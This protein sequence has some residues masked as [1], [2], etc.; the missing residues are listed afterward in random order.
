MTRS[1]RYTWETISSYLMT[2]LITVLFSLGL[3]GVIGAT[4]T[5][6]IVKEDSQKLIKEELQNLFDISK[7]F[8][9]SL[10]SLIELMAKYWISTEEGSTESNGL[11]VVETVEDVEVDTALSQFSPELVD[12]I[13]EEEEKVA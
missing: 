1:N 4:I 13:N 7:M 2:T 11:E 8:V 3:I 12:V 5:T 6:Y 10:K 9:G